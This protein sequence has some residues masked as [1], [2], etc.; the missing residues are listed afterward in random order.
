MLMKEFAVLRLLQRYNTAFYPKLQILGNSIKK[1]LNPMIFFQNLPE[2]RKSRKIVI[3][4]DRHTESKLHIPFCQAVVVH[5]TMPMLSPASERS[6]KENPHRSAPRQKASPP[7]LEAACTPGRL[8]PRSQAAAAATAAAA[9][10]RT[11]HPPPLLRPPPPAPWAVAPCAAPAAEASR[12][13]WGS[14]VGGPCRAAAE[15]DARRRP[16]GPAE[17]QGRVPASAGRGAARAD[18]TAARAVAEFYAEDDARQARD[19]KVATAILENE[20]REI[21]A[22]DAVRKAR[23]VEDA[24]H[25]R[26][27]DDEEEIN[28]QRWLKERDEEGAEAAKR[29]ARE[30]DDE[31][32]AEEIEKQEEKARLK[33]LAREAEMRSTPARRTRRRRSTASAG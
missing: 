16:R 5:H 4:N 1:F 28:R 24:E 31:L 10:A 14:A 33:A 15:H 12:R 22:R 20:R 25:A 32:L 7:P 29:V 17:P 27:A 18:A 21:Q 8:Q 19:G 30:V 11:P 3:L 13:C 6:D 26:R 9:A 23:E 2:N